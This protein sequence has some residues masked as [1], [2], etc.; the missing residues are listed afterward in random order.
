MPVS[1]VDLSRH[2]AH[3]AILATV[4]IVVK[5]ITPEVTDCPFC[6]RTGLTILLDPTEVGPKWLHCS[7]CQWA[8]NTLDAYSKIVQVTDLPE[9]IKRAVREGKCCNP[10]CVNPESIRS[11]IRG[12]P[13]RRAELLSIWNQ[14]TVNVTG[15]PRPDVLRHLQKCG[16]WNGNGSRFQDRIGRFIGAA[17]KT[18]LKKIFG[19]Y[20]KRADRHLINKLPEN[21]F[22]TALVV[23]FQDAPGRMCAFELIDQQGERFL[24]TMPGITPGTVEQSPEGGLAILDSIKPFEPVVVLN[25]HKVWLTMHVRQ[26]QQFDAALPILL[27][28]AY[29]DLAWRSVTADKAVFWT[30]EVNLDL[31]KQVRK[32][33]N[34]CIVSQPW[35]FTETGRSTVFAELPVQLIMSELI[36]KARPWP[37][38]FV[39]WVT[40]RDR[41]EGEALQAFETL[42]L[43]PN[44]RDSVLS[45]ANHT[46]R[47]RLEHFLGATV[48]PRS[49]NVNGITVMEHGGGWS[50][51][52]PRG[53]EQILDGIIHIDEEL[54]DIIQGVSYLKGLIRYRT[55]TIEFIDPK[56]Q[57]EKDP[58]GWLTQKTVRAALGSP[59][60]NPKYA[61]QL[62]DIARAFSSPRI[63]TISTQLGIQSDGS[64]VFPKF[65]L[66]CGAVEESESY[67]P[68]PAMPM[69]AVM[70][71]VKRVADTRDTTSLTRSTVIAGFCAMVGNWL[72]AH[73]GN[74]NR[75]IAVL[76]ENGSVA[77]AAV[78]HLVGIFGL[79]RLV[80]GHRKGTEVSSFRKQI[81]RHNCPCVADRQGSIS[82][83]PASATD[84]VII[85]VS[86]EEYQALRVSGARWLALQGTPL[87]QENNPLPPVDDFI[88]YLADLQRRQYELPGTSELP[89]RLIEDFCAWYE[90]YLDRD[91]RE[92]CQQALAALQMGGRPGLEL[93]RLAALMVRRGFIFSHF[94]PLEATRVERG[95]K[96][97]K[98]ASRMTG[99]VIDVPQER[100]FVSHQAI[101]GTA[102]RIRVPMPDFDAATRDLASHG[103]L[104]ENTLGTEG[105]M[106]SLA[107]WNEAIQDLK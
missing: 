69:G 105:W 87:R 42:A 76:G 64:I 44:E 60:C 27:Y 48:H 68:D 70:P 50:V 40:D 9:A 82:A 43:T 58:E 104:L 15:V 73:R 4:G 21:G 23:G 66:V 85:P 96:R 99:V 49:V 107:V 53:E 62:L 36:K 61:R 16:L 103:Q 81:N 39:E 84:Q 12:Y 67:N 25:D 65:S 18:E 83:Y 11:Y 56:N 24:K 106:V 75:P 31:F 78:R 10:Q 52:R 63:R 72:E 86:V 33:G 92:T 29:T 71:P 59:H 77:W 8:G 100:V 55:K 74:P 47:H 19:Q 91:Q 102:G 97:L 3:T 89:Q 95:I 20:Y 1:P 79:P 98:A 57:I 41:P 22:Q 28:N 35:Y 51:A 46:Q 45:V 5:G 94:D 93:L 7:A 37:E 17:T 2:F 30:N 13:E 101:M 90:R 34:G 26:A 38:V 6:G 14:F 88:W 32:V 54:C 80:L